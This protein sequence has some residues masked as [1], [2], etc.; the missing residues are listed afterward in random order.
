MLGKR[1][2]RAGKEAARERFLTPRLLR[3]WLALFTECAIDDG[4]SRLTDAV[5]VRRPLVLVSNRGPVTFEAGRRG[6]ARHRRPR[7]GADRARAHR[8]VTWIA[9]AM[10]D[11]DVL[12]QSAT[13]AG[14]SR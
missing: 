10:T 1:L 12:A 9:S 4:L 2:G 5:L 14:R 3:D 11:E 13:A 6:P 8:E 7:D